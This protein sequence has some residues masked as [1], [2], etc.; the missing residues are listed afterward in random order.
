MNLRSDIDAAFVIVSDVAESMDKD[1]D[2]SFVTSSDRKMIGE[3]R[4]ALLNDIA[5]LRE[6]ADGLS[7]YLDGHDS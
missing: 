4:K 2:G 1:A 3:F 7:A 5:S 6:S